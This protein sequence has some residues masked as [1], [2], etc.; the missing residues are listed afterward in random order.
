MFGGFSD[1]EC[2]ASVDDEW[3]RFAGREGGVV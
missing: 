2:I 1:G 3:D